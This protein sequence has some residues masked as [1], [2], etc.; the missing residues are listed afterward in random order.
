MKKLF[1]LMLTIVMVMSLVACGGN[2]AGGNAGT[3]NPGNNSGTVGG[4]E[5]TSD[6]LEHV[7]LKIWFH[8]STVTP[9]A[10]ETVLKEVNAYLKEKMIL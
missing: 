10:S 2:N 7:T 6:A 8:G 4:K 5:D 9:E 1:T 3:D